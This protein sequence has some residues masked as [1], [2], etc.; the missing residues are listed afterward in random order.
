MDR[1]EDGDGNGQERLNGGKVGLVEIEETKEL[2]AIAERV[3]RK[4][5]FRSG[6]GMT[7]GG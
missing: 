7:G 6:M 1:K 5:W 2:V 3:G 4:E